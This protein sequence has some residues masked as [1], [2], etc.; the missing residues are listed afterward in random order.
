MLGDLF[1]DFPALRLV[2]PHGGG[3][4]PYHWGRY[5]GL[6]QDLGRPP[7]EAHLL[8]YVA[9]DTCVYYQR[10]IDLLLETIPTANVLFGSETVGAVR[11]N[12]PMTGNA[13]DDTRRYIDASP[14]LDADGRRAVYEENATRVY[15][16]LAAS[17]AVRTHAGVLS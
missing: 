3:A 10:G 4:V 8:P 5:R 1:A 11:G 2:L 15:P 12:D 13:F 16:R 9:F 7:L 17:T 14:A 6:A